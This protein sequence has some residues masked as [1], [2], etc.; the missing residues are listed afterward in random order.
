MK[1]VAVGLHPCL[2]IAV[3]S[4][5]IRLPLNLYFSYCL[6]LLFNLSVLE[7]VIMH[8]LLGYYSDT[9]RLKLCA[10]ELWTFLCILLMDLIMVVSDLF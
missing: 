4:G 7:M 8:F 2:V 1:T 9:G 5:D 3:E 6:L 10:A